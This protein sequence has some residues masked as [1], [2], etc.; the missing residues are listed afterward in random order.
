KGGALIS[1]SPD[2]AST[3][4]QASQIAQKLLNNPATTSLGI[5]QPDKLKITVNTTTAK[6]IGIDLSP[7]RSR[8]DI[9]LYP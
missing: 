4:L 5:K 6:L 2:Y 7:L 1:I 9:V 8:T 3:G